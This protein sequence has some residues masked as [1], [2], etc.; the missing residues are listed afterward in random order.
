MGLL[1]GHGS[2]A[3]GH[4]S[5][6]AWVTGSWVN[7]S[8]PLP[9]LVVCLTNRGSVVPDVRTNDGL[10]L[11]RADNLRPP[12]DMWRD[13]VRQG[14]RSQPTTCTWWRRYATL[15][16]NIAFVTLTVRV[17]STKVIQRK[18]TMGD[19]I[20]RWNQSWKPWFETKYRFE[21]EIEPKHKVTLKFWF[22]TMF[23]LNSV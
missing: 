18:K 2:C 6:S 12:V 5:L 10:V 4:G 11:I 9:A 20:F 7:A 8:D 13:A 17:R 15:V 14:Q 22:Q 21:T 23:N 3:M 1:V 16:D 19:L